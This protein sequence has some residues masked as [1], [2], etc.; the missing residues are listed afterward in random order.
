MNAVQCRMARAALQ[1]GVRE[2]AAL[3]QVST[4]TVTK[5]ERGEALLPRTVEA[6]QRALEAQG[7]EFIE[8]P[9]G[10]QLRDTESLSG[11]RSTLP[12]RGRGRIA[13][14]QHPRARATQSSRPA[15]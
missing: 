12:E 2:L 4:G 1:L 9:P 5:L 11:G 13:A 7:V 14:V 10:A 8:N 3:A 6:I 15:D